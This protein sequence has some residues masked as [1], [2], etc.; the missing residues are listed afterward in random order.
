MAIQDQTINELVLSTNAY[1]TNEKPIDMYDAMFNNF[2][3]LTPL[4]SILTKLSSEE[5]A[6]SRIDWIEKETLPSQVVVT[7][8]ATATEATLTITD[9]YTY[10]RNHDFLFNP[11]TFELIKVEG[12]ATI[13]ASVDVVRGWGSTT[14]TAIVA[15]SVLEIAT[16][17][18]FEGSEE[19][20]PRSVVNTQFHN[21]TAE[22]HESVRTSKRVQNER[23]YF[24]GKGTKR[25]ENQTDMFRSFKEKLEKALLFSYRADVAS[26]ESGKTSQNIKTMEGIVS[27][28]RN[29]TNFLDVNGVFTE[30]IFDDWLTDIYTNMPDTNMLTAF[31]APHVYKTINRRAKP[32]IRISTNQEVYGMKLKRYEGAID[33]DLISHPML[34][35]A[36]SGWM[37]LLDLS[38]VKILYQQRPQLELDVAMKRYN[39]VED[40]YSA[41]ITMIVA[42]EIRHAMAVNIEG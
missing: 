11:L 18:Y 12:F 5:F 4:V 29:G 39:Y 24:G 15:G 34:Q 27:K 33:V 31:C 32:S 7:A 9:H 6:N 2:P 26:T 40:K 10:L 17:S 3:E 36:M 8:S 35:G 42:N 28:L 19:A 25:L 20:N 23:T 13:D 37:F 41:F 16:N 22:I 38:R 1:A 21:F 30:S 14:G